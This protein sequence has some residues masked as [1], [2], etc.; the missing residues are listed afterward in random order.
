MSET[1]GQW[2]YACD[3]YGK[4]QHSRKA[5][6]YSSVMTP[7]GQRLVTVAG[8][9]E[10]WADARLMA[11]VPEMLAFVRVASKADGD[12]G[13]HA[14][15]L[16][17]MIDSNSAHRKDEYKAKLLATRVESLVDEC[18]ENGLTIGTT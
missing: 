4:V 17:A 1:T 9:I 16:L 10:N 12:L 7:A 15:A 11:A 3:S 6:V 18:R 2:E 14:R 13:E 5:C 8:R